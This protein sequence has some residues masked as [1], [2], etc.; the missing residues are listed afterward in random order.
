MGSQLAV[1]A[2]YAG[3][4]AIVGP[5]RN[6]RNHAEV[7]HVDVVAG[8]GRIDAVASGIGRIDAAAAGIEAITLSP[9]LGDFNEDLVAFGLDELREQM[10]TMLE[11][12]Q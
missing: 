7:D 3:H 10:R 2:Q 12:T 1:N 8:V 11:Q 4:D 9:R 6:R 5:I